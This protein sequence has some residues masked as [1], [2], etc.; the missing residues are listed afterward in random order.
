MPSASTTMAAALNPGVFE[1][2]RIETVRSPIA[3]LD[4]EIGSVVPL[5]RRRT[6]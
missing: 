2:R 1:R 6:W 3:S 4:A 5:R